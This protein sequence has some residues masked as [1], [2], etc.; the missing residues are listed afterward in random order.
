MSEPSIHLMISLFPVLLLLA[1]AYRVRARGP[2]GF[3]H[4]I[5]DWS[6]VSEHTRR[7]AG[8]ATSDVLLEIAVLILIHRLYDPADPSHAALA[9]LLLSASIG[10]LVVGLLVYLVYL[11]KTDGA[12]KHGRR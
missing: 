4:G 3:V 11:Q 8:R 6:K 12:G 7:R 5:G 9:G 1:L 2:Q 10:L